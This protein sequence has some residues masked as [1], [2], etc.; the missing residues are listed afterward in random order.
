MTINS[1]NLLDVHELSVVTRRGG[2]RIVDDVSFA[3]ESGSIHALVGESG[4][5][6]STIL[7][8]I[9]GL[10][11]PAL[12]VESGSVTVDGIETTTLSP[13]RY[14]AL[15]GRTIGFVPQDPAQSLN[16]TLTVGATVRHALRSYGKFDRSTIQRRTV[17][18]LDAAQLPRAASRLSSYPHELSG[19]LK[20]RV[21]IAVALAGRPKLILADEPT[22]ALD[23]TVQKRILDTLQQLTVDRGLGLLLVTHDLALATDRSDRVT[24]LFRGRVAESGSPTNILERAEHPFTRKLVHASTYSVS[25]PNTA[26]HLTTPRPSVCTV[27]DV[28]KTYD[29]HVDAPDTIWAL[30]GSSLRIEAGETVGLIGESGSG[31][32]TLGKIVAGNLA[33]TRGTLSVGNVAYIPQNPDATLDPRWTVARVVAE[34]LRLNRTPSAHIS[35]LVT[36]VLGRVG[37]DAGALSDARPH[38]LSGGQRQ[39]VAIARALITSP[40]LI[41]CDEILSAL[42]ASSRTTILDLLVD[43]QRDTGV[44]Y[45]FITHDLSVAR[46]F[47]T[48]L[49]VM[50][51]GSIVDHDTTSALFAAP[52]SVHTRELIDAIPAP[53]GASQSHG[54]RAQPVP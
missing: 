51:D 10:L 30:R 11:P 20:Q 39:R 4:S 42:D 14:R 1:T 23:T 40:A 33:P 15:R 12:V 28:A 54:G 21:L 34:P 7:R 5:G 24:V 2:Q 17:E 3:V 31:K 37:L 35:D 8:A 50:H 49:A 32:S 44:A 6:K 26:P 47:C 9:D 41:V 13:R 18:L 53:A 16:P 38:Q 36:T 29:R 25:A 46:A 45:L 19:G 52:R 43:L 22:S 48:T 27:V